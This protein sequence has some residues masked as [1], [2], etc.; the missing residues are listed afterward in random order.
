VSRDLDEQDP[1]QILDLT[2]AEAEQA[3][4]ALKIHR[5]LRHT[6]F[7]LLELTLASARRHGRAELLLV[8]EG[9]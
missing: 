6:D 5:V 8:I 7:K 2:L 9:R 1:A 3:Y 4:A